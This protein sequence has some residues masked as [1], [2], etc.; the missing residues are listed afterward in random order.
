MVVVDVGANIG[1]YTLYAA[2]ALRGAG[3]ARI[4][5]AGREPGEAATALRE[6]GI[7]EFICAGIDA[8]A[9]VREALAVALGKWQR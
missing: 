1:I 4:Y 9:I 6:A 3:A 5:L 7:A 8:L 2:R